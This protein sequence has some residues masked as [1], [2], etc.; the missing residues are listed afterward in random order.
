M[1]A[2]EVGGNSL[3]NVK[4]GGEKT[5]GK[6]LKLSWRGGAVGISTEASF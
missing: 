5:L 3:P 2:R 4:V 1:G 6:V